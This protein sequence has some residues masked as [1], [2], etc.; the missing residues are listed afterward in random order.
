[1]TIPRDASVPSP[2]LR[3]TEQDG[4][5]P[6][7]QLVRPAWADLSGPWSFAFDDGDIGIAEHWAANPMFD[8]IITV[9]FPPES[10]ASGIGD[11]GYHR[12]VWYSRAIDAADFS[13]AGAGDDKPRIVAHFGAVDYRA[14][15]WLN[16]ELLGS[17]EGGH[18]PFEFDIT[19][20]IDPSRESQTLVVRAEDD[21]EDVHQPRGKQ[22]WQDHPH[23]VW[24]D[25]TTGIWQPVWLEAVP[26]SRI[27]SLNWMSDVASATARLSLR[28]DSPPTPGTTVTT[29]IRSGEIVLAHST[30]DVV[31]AATE[32]TIDLPALANGQDLERLLWSPEHPHLLDAEVML[33][34]GDR[35]ASYLGLRTISA[36]HRAFTINGRPRYLRSILSQGFWPESHLAAPSADALRAEAQLVLDLGFNAARVHQKIE[37]PRFLFWADKLGLLLWEEMP[38]AFAYSDSAVRR[39]TTEWM[40]AIDRDRSHPSIVAWVPL[41]ESWGVQHIANDASMLAYAR[42]L[43]E[44]TRALD[45]SRPVISNDG[46][47]HAKSDIWTIHDYEGSPDIL[48][49]RYA[50]DRDALL[51]D[52]GPAG[53]RVLLDPDSDVDQPVMLTEFGGIRIDGSADEGAWGYTTA[54]SADDFRERLTS[55]VTAVRA[56]RFLAG[57]CYTQLTDTQ[58]EQ[59]GLVDENRRPKLATEDYMAIFGR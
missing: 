28:L 40:A 6:R 12:V 19:H 46:W 1:M 48:R 22:E 49:D 7:P 36:A 16:G 2:A 9:P 56:S 32:H 44:L 21:P 57:Y 59:N 43:Y 33:S 20:A 55:V 25:R 18:T 29:T 8:R 47:E 5:Y 38:S 14:S 31:G 23:A 4:T 17:H 37:D 50:S 34:T 35:V 27:V 52:V 41:N 39:T 53:R 42:A 30:S 51:A 45:P 26:D 3:A 15:V 54:R 24:Y 10:K 11:T 13:A 58:Q